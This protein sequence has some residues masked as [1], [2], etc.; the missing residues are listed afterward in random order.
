MESCFFDVHLQLAG[1]PV[2]CVA[3]CAD[4]PKHFYPAIPREMNHMTACRNE[5]LTDGTTTAMVNADFPIALELGQPIPF[6]FA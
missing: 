3:V 2:F 5:D 6:Q 4:C 1:G